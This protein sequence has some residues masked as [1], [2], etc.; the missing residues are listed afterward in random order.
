MEVH[1]RKVSLPRGQ[2]GRLAKTKVRACHHCIANPAA[3]TL[4][5]TLYSLT[6]SRA[7][8]AL[9]DAARLTVQVSAK[10]CEAARIESGLLCHERE[11]LG[12]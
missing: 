1:P 7:Q 10:S 4:Q 3:F 12:R 2:A 11:Q 9:R 5:A 8:I 6:Q